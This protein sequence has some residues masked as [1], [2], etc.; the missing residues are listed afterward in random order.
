MDD[1]SIATLLFVWLFCFYIFSK[2]YGVMG[3]GWLAD[4]K[5]KK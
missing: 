1:I 3:I 2:A 4:K 5:V